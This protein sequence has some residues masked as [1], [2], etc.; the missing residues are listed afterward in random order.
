M[1]ARWRVAALLLTLALTLALG[2]C[3]DDGDAQDADV[4]EGAVAVIGDTEIS[5]DD[6]EQQKEALRRA[7]PKQSASE[8]EQEQDDP[9]AR[10]D[11]KQRLNEQALSLLLSAQAF[12]QEAAER[13]IKVDVAEARRRWE[14]V[15]DKQFKTAKARRTFL[16]GQTEE[17]VVAQLRLQMLAEAIYAQ[18]AEE[19]GGGKQGAKA[20]ARFQKDLYKQWQGKTT[21]EGIRAAGCPAPSE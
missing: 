15:A 12:E 19:A 6:L 1:T 4:P 3:G 16:G 7:Q 20:A 2:A 21:C 11:A 9:E 8:R 18:V 14:S 5:T 17:D 13:G 10:A